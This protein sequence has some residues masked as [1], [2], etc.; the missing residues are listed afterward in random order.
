MIYSFLANMRSLVLGRHTVDQDRVSCACMVAL[1]SFM[2]ELSLLD[3]FSREFFIY[4]L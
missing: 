3:E 4:I 2:F 1:P